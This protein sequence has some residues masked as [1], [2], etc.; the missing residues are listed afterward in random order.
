MIFSNF[1]HLLKSLIQRT[2]RGRAILAGI[3]LGL[4]VTGPRA[5]AQGVIG[6]QWRWVNVNF[7]EQIR[8]GLA[9]PVGGLGLTWNQCVG[10]AGLTQTGLLDSNGTAT[11]VGFTCDASSVYSWLDPE[12]KLLTGSAFNF[13][14]NAPMNVVINGLTPGKKYTL[15]LASYV[16]NESGSRN[17]YTTPNV[18]TS[19][20]TQLVDNGGPYGVSDR[21]LRG[22]NYTRFEN[23]QPDAANCIKL[24]LVSGS[25]SERAHLSGFQLVEN[26]AAATS[27]YAAWLAG[28]S[29]AS[30]PGA[31]LALDGDPDCDRYTNMEE[32]Q[33]GLDPT[34]ANSRAG[35]FMTDFW[36]GLSGMTVGELQASPKFFNEPDSVTFKPL[37]GLKFTGA[38]SGSRSRAYI[39]PTATG[40]YTFWL[41]ARTSANLLLSSDVGQG[42]YAK[43]RIA[44]IGTDLG[45]GTGIGRDHSNLWDCFAS[46]QSAPI[47]LGAGQTY[48]LEIDHHTGSQGE[49][50]TSLAWACNGGARE[51][52][53]DARVSS[54]VKTPDDL[55]DDCLP[56]AWE[57]QYGLS[58]SDNGAT[59]PARQGENGDCDGDGLTNREEYL[60]GTD[61]TDSDTDGD[62][63]SDFTEIRN[64][65][66]N[67]RVSNILTKD[68]ILTVDLVRDLV[69]SSQ[70]Q[71]RED[72][73]VSDTYRN[74][75]SWKI[76]LTQ[77]GVFQV[78]VKMRLSVVRGLSSN[79]WFNVSLDGSKL[80]RQAVHFDGQ[81]RTTVLIDLP[82]LAAGIHELR[83]DL[84][85][86]SDLGSLNLESLTVLRPGGQ[87]FDT[88][89][90]TDSQQLVL[91]NR[92]HLFGGGTQ[93]YF[94]PY[95]IEGRSP[96]LGL[97]T[98]YS[99]GTLRPLQRG[100][101]V[102][103]WRAD[104]P[105]GDFPVAVSANFEN[106]ALHQSREI[107]WIPLDLTLVHVLH[108]R[109]GD[110]L[111]FTIPAAA[112]NGVRILNPEGNTSQ[113]IVEGGLGNCFFPS[114]GRYRL[115][116]YDSS[117]L[118][119][120]SNFQIHAPLFNDNITS[121]LLGKILTVAVA[122]SSSELAL[123]GG[124]A[125]RTV[126][127]LTQSNGECFTLAL[128]QDG[129]ARL[130]F[131]APDSGQLLSALPLTILAAADVLATG[132]CGGFITA[133]GA[134]RGAIYQMA[135][136]NLPADWTIE[137]SIFKAGVV[138]RD[139][140]INQTF[141]AGNL[142][143]G[144]L[145]LE[146]LYPGGLVGGLCH[147]YTIRNAQGQVVR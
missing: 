38:Y 78:E 112:G 124:A 88:D 76:N 8:S 24:S 132:H 68:K 107:R 12:L 99:E 28:F 96:S 91:S 1:S 48:Y 80:G 17:V 106:G 138:F 98:V 55:D 75:A 141:R 3:S 83:L 95:T 58:L 103:G 119:V 5:T 123:D 81:H 84:D 27:P 143:N 39:T 86:Y 122:D 22:A 9:G 120:E 70:W 72:R 131:R 140:T 2:A 100:V 129:D 16:P 89:G 130:G 43:R 128:L 137:V 36:D 50:H 42:K 21:W 135:F 23:I 25:A 44:A 19:G 59:D 147:N 33:L 52:I 73:L 61:P 114:P 111:R 117:G 26:P 127:R 35:V 46:Q 31:D 64:Y 87:D 102:D 20:S 94:S 13:T 74:S 116:Y 66:S 139:G 90:L 37:S 7:D 54:Y 79:T 53:P 32:Y 145:S 92:S 126:N 82:A 77:G 69:A 4:L 71:I 142:V 14:R 57:A 45:H 60:L 11:S 125:I 18:T 134:I 47:P 110:S 93:T 118:I 146:F 67:P 109:V 108:A 51:V 49:S 113:A 101:G 62:G 115:Q 104:I 34:L 10:N 15:Y 30:I 133:D 29:F 63:V 65:Y 121:G 6:T 97:A 136:S 144:I 105:L 85:G 41:S 56:D 40:D